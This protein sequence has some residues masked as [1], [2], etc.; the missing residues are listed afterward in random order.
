MSGVHETIK[1]GDNFFGIPRNLISKIGARWIPIGNV[2][3]GKT[4]K[5]AKRHHYQTCPECG[6]RKKNIRRHYQLYHKEWFYETFIKPLE[7]GT[8][9]ELYGIRF[10]ETP[11]IGGFHI[12][13]DHLK[14]LG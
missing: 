3:F 7:K 14:A 4:A 5:H 12:K 6:E 8:I 13:P 10:V 9:G 1:F 11:K 2:L